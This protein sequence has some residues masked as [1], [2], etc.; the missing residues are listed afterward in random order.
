MSILPPVDYPEIDKFI[1][2]GLESL[3]VAYDCQL[4]LVNTTVAFNS[5]VRFPQDDYIDPQLANQDGRNAAVT[6]WDRVI[7]LDKDW[8]TLTG[9]NEYIVVCRWN[10]AVNQGSVK[11][12]N[13][14]NQRQV[15]KPELGFMFL[16]PQIVGTP[17]PV[18]VNVNGNNSTE[19]NPGVINPLNFGATGLPTRSA[20]YSVTIDSM[21]QI[22]AARRL[23]YLIQSILAADAFLV[24]YLPCR[25]ELV[26][27]DDLTLGDTPQTAEGA[28]KLGVVKVPWTW[29]STRA[30]KTFDNNQAFLSRQVVFVSQVN[31]DLSNTTVNDWLQGS[32]GGDLYNDETTEYLRKGVDFVSSYQYVY[33]Q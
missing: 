8:Q 27:A 31:M 7:E 22:V 9:Y 18:T 11:V 2:G 25:A 21:N 6:M 10:N 17:A 3:P 24:V 30:Y 4:G 16:A 1:L 12:D 29:M 19:A 13:Q 14:T 32:P 33:N 15:P 26:N 5:P 20:W 28:I 23:D